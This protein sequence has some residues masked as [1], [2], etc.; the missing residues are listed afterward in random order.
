[1]K[2]YIKTKGNSLVLPGAMQLDE[3]DKFENEASL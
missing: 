2:E 1:M 3:K